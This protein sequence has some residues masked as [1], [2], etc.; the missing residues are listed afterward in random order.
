MVIFLSGHTVGASWVATNICENLV[1]PSSA[2]K[3]EAV[4]DGPWYYTMS[5]ARGSECTPL[6]P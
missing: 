4:S 5:Q 3:M 1:P 2:L 6:L